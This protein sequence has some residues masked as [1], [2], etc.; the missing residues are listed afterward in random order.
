[1]ALDLDFTVNPATYRHYMNG[2]AMVLHCHH[3]MSLYTKTAEQFA[4]IDGPA[5]LADS[6]EES[7]RPIF[8]DYFK[9]NGVNSPEDRIR[10]CSEFYSA[11]GMG[12]MDI[13]GDA[14]GGEVTLSASHVDQG[15]IK[16]WDKHEKPINHVTRGFIAASFASVFDQ[17]ASSYEVT[18]TAAIVTGAEQ[19]QFQ[20]KKK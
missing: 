19:S 5:L 1:M 18:E 8:D 13:N 14:E 17:P 4:D 20:V 3:Y 12:A 10:V 11:M 6:M 7:V 15:W 16:K 9:K 2:F